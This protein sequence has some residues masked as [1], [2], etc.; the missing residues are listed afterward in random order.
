MELWFKI[1]AL[2]SAGLIMYL[3]TLLADKH[4]KLASYCMGYGFSAIL[5]GMLFIIGKAFNWF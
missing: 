2:W 4:M 3:C 5:F 1:S